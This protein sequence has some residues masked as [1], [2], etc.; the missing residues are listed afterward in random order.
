MPFLF[1]PLKPELSGPLT[2]LI[3]PQSYNEITEPPKLFGKKITEILFFYTKNLKD[4]SSFAILQL[5]CLHHEDN[6][7]RDAVNPF[8]FVLLFQAGT[9]GP[10]K[11]LIETGTHGAEK[12][13]HEVIG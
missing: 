3:R 9:E 10:S 12:S 13:L 5:P 2:F 7:L 8:G 4:P 11:G 1:A 6:A